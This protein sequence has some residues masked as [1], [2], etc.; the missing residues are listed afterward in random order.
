MNRAFVSV[1]LVALLVG[2][3]IGFLWWGAPA[4]RL[5]AE[6]AAT[7]ARAD[8]L[9]DQVNEL[10]ATTQ[11]L[12]G[13]LKTAEADLRREKEMNARLQMVVSQGKK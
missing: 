12:G 4:N 2:V 5:Q 1:G 9:E 6:M 13:Q 11:R 10:Q 3:L 8:R 7:R